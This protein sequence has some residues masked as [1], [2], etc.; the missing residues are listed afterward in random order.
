MAVLSRPALACGLLLL[1]SACNGPLFMIP[2]GAL[3]GPE[4][5]IRT[6]PIPADGDVIAL[7]TRP[8][9]PY[10]VYVNAVA[11]DGVLHIDPTAE[12]GWYQHLVADGQVRVRLSSDDTIYTARAQPVTDEAV[13]ARFEDDRI[14]FAL[15]PRG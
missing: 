7:E 8:A 2:G 10:S 5:S 14:V 1:L 12:R 15:V 11:I 4:A 6:A 13:L 3:K 9:D